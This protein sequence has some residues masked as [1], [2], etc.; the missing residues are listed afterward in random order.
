MLYKLHHKLTW[1]L[2]HFKITHSAGRKK[3]DDATFGSQFM[4]YLNLHS[5]QCLLEGSYFRICVLM[6]YVFKPVI[7]Q[8]HKPHVNSLQ[9]SLC[10]ITLLNRDRLGTVT[11]F[12]TL[13]Y[14][15]TIFLFIVTLLTCGTVNFK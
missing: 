5:R 10:C 9:H 12:D 4:S 7:K 15:F 1:G 8:L 2:F 13:H 14:R 11:Q 6:F 3:K